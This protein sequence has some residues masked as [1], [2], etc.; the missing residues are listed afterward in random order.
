ML[1][2]NLFAAAALATA[3]VL[4][5]CDRSG[6]TAAL[7]TDGILASVTSGPALSIL[8]FLEATPILTSI[9]NVSSSL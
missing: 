3:L 7:D 1:R 2:P 8:P 6:P 9:P 5:A 4:T